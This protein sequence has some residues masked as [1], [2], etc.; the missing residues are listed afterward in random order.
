MGWQPHPA[1]GPLLVSAG[2]AITVA[3]AVLRWRRIP[4]ALALAGLMAGAA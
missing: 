4:G 3:V 1:F 2:I